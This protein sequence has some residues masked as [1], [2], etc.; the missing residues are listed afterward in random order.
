MSGNVHVH[1]PWRLVQN[2]V[3]ERRDLQ[4]VFLQG[5]HNRRNFVF[6]QYQIAHHHRVLARAAEGEPRPQ[7]ECRFHLYA[8][9]S[10]FEVA[11][12][13]PEFIGPIAL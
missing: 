11:T 9:D 12:R 7:G 2:V 5:Q 10:H 8:V 1:H 4:A 3:V 6:R 13:Q